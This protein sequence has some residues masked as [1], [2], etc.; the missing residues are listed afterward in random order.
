MRIT[1]EKKTQLRFATLSNFIASIAV[2]KV[3]HMIYTSVKMELGLPT[4][5]E[6]KIIDN[7]VDLGVILFM[8]LM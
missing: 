8:F 7:N 2:E 5:Q 4:S 6:G 3:I 1:N